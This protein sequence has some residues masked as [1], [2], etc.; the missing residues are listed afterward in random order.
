MNK[1]SM[2]MLVYPYV[3]AHG[4]LP[5]KDTRQNG[6]EI[7]NIERHYGQHP[8]FWSQILNFGF[9][10]QRRETLPLTVNTRRPPLSS[11]RLLV[12]GRR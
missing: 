2:R 6:Q 4:K 3:P 5:N 8:R 9:P 12:E 10:D 11:H 1:S 7:A